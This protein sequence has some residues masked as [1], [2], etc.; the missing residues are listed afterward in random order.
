M[1]ADQ[2]DIISRRGRSPGPATHEANNNVH[3]Q[4]QG[5]TGL[6]STEDSRSRSTSAMTSPLLPEDQGWKNN[7]EGSS[8]I[9]SLQSSK[10]NT[11]DP[12]HQSP[13]NVVGDEGADEE[14]AI[15]EPFERTHSPAADLKRN[16]G[17]EYEKVGDRGVTKMHRFSLYETASRYYLVGGDVLDTRF[18]V[19][20][21]DRTSDAGQLNLSEDDIVYTKKEMGQLLNAID[22]GNKSVGG[23][24]LRCTTWGLLGFIRFTGPYYMLLITKRRQ[25]AMIGGHYVYQIDGTELVQLTTSQGSRF[26]SEARNAEESRFLGILNSLDLTRSFYYSYSYD[27]TRSLQHNMMRERQALATNSAFPHGENFNSMFVW[28]HYLLEPA[29]TLLKNTYDWCQPVI[30]GYIDQAG[31]YAII[32]AQK[33]VNNQ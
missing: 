19:L 11:V 32:F 21:I 22:D 14:P 12:R 26:K 13:K 17:A 24:K 25:I 31:Q 30:H 8:S 18:R 6:S 9:P 15:A 3:G 5:P 33:F 20:K 16:K 7:E 4:I 27:I 10:A 29:E 28:N 1:M 2:A 23:M